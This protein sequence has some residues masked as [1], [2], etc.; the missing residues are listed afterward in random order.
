MADKNGNVDV[1]SELAK[2]RAENEVLKAKAEAKIRV[3]FKVGKAGGLSMYGLG[4]YPITL[5]YSQWMRLL[6]HANDIREALE[7]N[8]DKL[9]SKPE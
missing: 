5:Y 4:R 6:D 7:A 3:S 2:L 8:K 9:A 1:Q